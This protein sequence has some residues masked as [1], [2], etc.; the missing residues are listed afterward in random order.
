MEVEEE[1]WGVEMGMVCVKEEVVKLYWFVVV[2]KEEVV[3]VKEEVFQV[4]KKVRE[5]EEKVLGGKVEVVED[6][7]VGVEESSEV[8]KGFSMLWCWLKRRIRWWSWSRTWGL[9]RR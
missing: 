4:E 5:I 7:V 2:V 9:R 1:V 8:M 6:E 3:G